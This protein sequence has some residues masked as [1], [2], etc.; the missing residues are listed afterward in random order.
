VGP[1]A[2][3][4]VALAVWVA[5]AHATNDAYAAFLPPLLPRIMA[6]LGLSVTLAATLTMTFSVSQSLL[7]PVAGFVA[8]R[9][10]PRTFVVAGPVMSG[11]FLSLLGWAPDLGLLLVLLVLGGLGSALFHPPG[12]SFAARVREGRGS[13]LR[14][15]VFSF[16]GALGFSLGPLIAV[17]LVGRFG[18]RG[19]AWAMIPAL[20][21]APVLW[22]ALPAGSGP[23]KRRSPP[24]PKVVAKL[25]AGP[26]GL[27]FGISAVAAFEQ[28]VF[29]TFMPIIA[30][31]DGRSEA[32]GAALLTVYL[33]AQALGTLAGGFLTDRVDRVRL[34]VVL[35]LVALPAHALAL[36]AAAG[37]P[38]GLSAA[39]VAGFTN[40][41]MLPPLVILAQELVPD[42]AA[43]GS[44]IAMGLAWGT[45]S[46]LLPLSGALGD[47]IGV[48]EGA[49]ASVPLFLLATMLAL[50]PALRR[51]AESRTA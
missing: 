26:L 29:V 33:G 50:H 12:A 5:V 36:A 7:Q 39:A 43:V 11:V 21:L 1:G 2:R 3:S 49:V 48:R 10:G 35:S 40:M 15:S 38:L 28:R 14:F 20:I 32:V 6:D 13:G 16:G 45:G 51:R 9:V 19:L 18:L 23:E 34:L 17:G 42:G 31:Q 25:L 4:A 8:D 27:V 22:R 44:G 37:S 30:A 47:Q 46:L 24:G 41:A